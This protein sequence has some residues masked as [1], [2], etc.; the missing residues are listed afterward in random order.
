MNLFVVLI[1]ALFLVS[2]LEIASGG[3]TD[4][5]CTCPLLEKPHYAKKALRARW[6]V[7]TMTWGVLSTSSSRLGQVHPFGNV[8]SF[9]DGHCDLSTGVP[10]FYG[11]FMDQSFADMKENPSASFTLSEAAL[12]SVC[13]S[14]ALE[15]CSINEGDPESPLCARLTLTGRLVQVDAESAEYATIRQG[16]FHRHPTMESWPD[17]HGWA[18]VKLEVE[19]IWFIDFFGGASILDV[20]EYLEA[21]LDSIDVAHGAEATSPLSTDSASSATSNESDVLLWV[22]SLLTVV[23]IGLIA[24]HIYYVRT[25]QK[26]RLEYSVPEATVKP[27]E[28]VH[29]STQLELATAA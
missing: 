7:H 3:K 11:S 4:S 18:I 6:M 17:D 25:G 20:Q 13:D 29:E 28:D 9:I 24:H 27:F 23:M 14:R 21:P 26:T 10:Y 19:D 1:E 2:S 12:P 22:G 8:Y 15:S 5:S 16:F